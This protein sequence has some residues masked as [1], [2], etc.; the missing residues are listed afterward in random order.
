MG[1]KLRGPRGGCDVVAVGHEFV[2]SSYFLCPALVGAL[3]VIE[4]RFNRSMIGKK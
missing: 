1:S 4:L 3:F 2:E